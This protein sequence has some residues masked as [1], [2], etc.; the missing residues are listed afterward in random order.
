M[1]QFELVLVGCALAILGA[2]RAAWSPCGQSMLAS[3]TPIGERSRGFSWR[4]TAS[5]FA[6]GAI[7]G[8][9][10]GGAALG[11]IGTVLP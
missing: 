1:T 10:A 6:V 5:A 4:V 9:V 3:L 2:L 8:G 11:A 7:G